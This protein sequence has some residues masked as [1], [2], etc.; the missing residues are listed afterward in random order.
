MQSVIKPQER[1]V[2]AKT[3]Q[4]TAQ[5]GAD[6]HTASRR[7]LAGQSDPSSVMMAYPRD[8]IALTPKETS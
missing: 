8:S 3:V 4:Q 1:S 6:P 5:L 7:R 2:F